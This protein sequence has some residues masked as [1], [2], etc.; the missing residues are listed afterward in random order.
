MFS[1]VPLNMH[2]IS[3]ALEMLTFTGNTLPC[4][5]STPELRLGSCSVQAS[6][7][8]LMGAL[9]AGSESPIGV[10]ESGMLRPFQ[11]NY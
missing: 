4:T 8:W 9:I 11:C 7:P 6:L 10:T 1:P 3:A 2:D 5:L